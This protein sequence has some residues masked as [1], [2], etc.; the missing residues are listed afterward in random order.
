[1]SEIYFHVAT[2]SDG[3]GGQPG[4]ESNRGAHHGLVAWQLAAVRCTE[5]F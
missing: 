5:P 3:I 1:M 4:S 2:V